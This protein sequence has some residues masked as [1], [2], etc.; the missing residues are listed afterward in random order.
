MKSA[1]LC[2]GVIL[3]L[4]APSWA[5]TLEGTYFFQN[6]LAAQ[7]GG[8]P[9]LTAVNPTGTSGFVS[10]P[11]L[12]GRTVYHFGGTANPPAQQGGLS[13]NTTA[14]LPVSNSYSVE[15]HFDFL[16]GNNAWRRILDVQNR[17]SDTG[18]YVDPSNQLD[19]YAVTS[20]GAAYTNGVY[21]DVTLTDNS[22]VVAAYLDGVAAFTT[23]TTV[24]DINNSGNLM[25][26]F[27]DNVVGGG[28]GEYSTGNLAALRVYSGALTAAEAAALAAD[29]FAGSTPPSVPEPG[30]CLLLG[31][32]LAAAAALRRRRDQ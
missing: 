5:A 7:Q 16:D 30:T 29:P 23:T 11:L 22:G 4:I 27:L 21:H 8:A 32:G 31:T 3:F 15:M 19:V 14:I 28:I 20:G 2:A 10:D 24:M 6:S 1:F 12:A 18:F 25:N 13:L 26:F 9:S 17:Q